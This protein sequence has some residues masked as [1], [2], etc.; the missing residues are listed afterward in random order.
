M[1]KLGRNFTNLFV[2]D[3]LEDEQREKVLNGEID[4]FSMNAI[5]LV[6]F[7]KR[8]KF[9]VDKAVEY[10]LDH[11]ELDCD[12]PS[13]YAA[14]SAAE[15]A[16]IRD[17]AEKKGISFSVHL[18]YSGIGSGVACIQEE[19]RQKAVEL[20]KLHIDF[21]KDIGALYLNMHP[22]T[23]P[24]Y[25]NSPLFLEKIEKSLLKSVLEL[26]EYAGEC[27]FH[28]E[29]N[30]SF[31]NIYVE[32]EVIIPFVEKCRENGAEVYFNLDI[33]HWF[34]RAEQGRE[35]P[36]KPEEVM[37]KIPAELVKELHLNDYVPKKIVFHPPL[38]MTEGFLRKENLIEYGK[39]VKNLEP[40]VIILE[41][42]AKTKEQIAARD[43][44][45]REETAYVRECLGL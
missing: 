42:A 40:E 26:A 22:G 11:I 8:V 24:F 23:A 18:S 4:L 15:R 37:K 6:E 10:G 35:I 9:Q 14:M 25:M 2:A 21:A 43:K 41:T 29:N 5:G 20:H 3:V 45:V 39:I 27:K 17:Y 30:V 33:G 32:P 1:I 19:D 16:E 38:H 31:D 12:V 44:L 13:P 28:I 36:E 34:T 7:K